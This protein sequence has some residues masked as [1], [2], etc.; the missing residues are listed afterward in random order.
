MIYSL[1]QTCLCGKSNICPNSDNIVARFHS[2]SFAPKPFPPS[3]SS[4]FTSVTEVVSVL[5]TSA[6]HSYFDVGRHQ[7]TRLQNQA[8]GRECWARRSVVYC[9]LDKAGPAVVG[10]LGLCVTGE[11]GE[12]GDYWLLA[13]AAAMVA[14][15]ASG[16]CFWYLLYWQIHSHSNVV[17]E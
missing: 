4:Y 8:C 10:I 12:C 14:I 11:R 1:H 5:S 3:A 7:L 13:A 16:L 15:Y 2:Y 6:T 9:S 17:P